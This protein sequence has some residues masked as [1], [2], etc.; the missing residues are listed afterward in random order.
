MPSFLQ[1]FQKL[2]DFDSVLNPLLLETVSV[3]S[4][5]LGKP[6]LIQT[7]TSIM[8]FRVLFDS[9]FICFFT[10]LLYAKKYA[11]VVF[12][13]PSDVWL[14]VTPWTVAHQASLS[15]PSPGVCPSLCSLYQWCCPAISP[16]DA[17]FFFCPQS[18]PAS[19]TFPMSCLFISDDQNTGISASAS[20]LPVNIQGWSPLSLIGLISLLS[21]GLSGVFSSTTVQRHQFFGVLPSS[22]SSSHNHT[23]PLGRP[24]PWPYGL[25]L[26]EQC[27]CFSTH[28]LGLSSPFRYH[29]LVVAR[30]PM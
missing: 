9:F 4:V 11:V 5:F 26:A 28:C 2:Y 29:C 19:G 30:G 6:W 27:L 23:W 13:S 25:L 7:K 18:F 1:N 22:W 21:K 14:F 17:L 16:S 20:V 15:L 12:Q 8:G 10:Y 3:I 24:Q